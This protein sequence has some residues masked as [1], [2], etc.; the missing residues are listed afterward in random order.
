M[1][2]L[3]FGEPASPVGLVFVHANGFNAMA[4]R[5]LL[6]PLSKRMRIWAPDLRGH[7]RTTLSAEPSGR[8][9][10]RDL[11][12]DLE[13]LLD[14]IDGPPVVL[15]GHSMGGT[16][17]LLAAAGRRERVSRLVLIDPVIW[18]RPATIGMNLP[19]V[20]RLLRRSALAEGARR[21]RAVFASR[22]EALAA[23]RGRG[24]FRGWED[25]WI[26]DFLVDGLT[27]SP[28][29][30]R[31]SCPPGWEASNYAA[32]AHDPWR[33]VRRVKRPMT[34]LRAETGSICNLRETPADAPWVDVRTIAGSGHM[35]PMHQPQAVGDA[36]LEAA[37]QTRSPSAAT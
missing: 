8:R 22:E 32:Q 9:N 35:V 36:L 5:R 1:A 16:A 27:E 17:G 19:L 2:V 28:E 13:H 31:L 33:A 4:Y 29:G 20:E 6:A 10:W 34:V 18:S 30:L 26:A 15:A 3:D 7:G 12:R 21:R 11:A 23:Y 25:G 14:R 24:A 37:M